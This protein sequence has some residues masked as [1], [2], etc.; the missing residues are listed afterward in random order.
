MKTIKS[1]ED[2]YKVIEE[3]KNTFV[4]FYT[5]WC[6][7]CFAVKPYLPQ[8]ELD[9]PDIEFFSMDRDADIELARHLNIF[10]IPSFIMFNNNEEI[11][12]FVSKFS[13]SYKEVHMFIKN[14]LEG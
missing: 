2:F 13:K 4:Y 1:M 14:T 3:P 12:R 11:G 8:L 9:Y 6:P 7:D 10:G 5:N